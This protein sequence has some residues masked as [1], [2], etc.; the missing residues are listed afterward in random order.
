[1][2]SLREVREKS[3]L[4]FPQEK[5]EL[6]VGDICYHS[7]SQ[8]GW[9]TPRHT[10]AAERG[11]TVSRVRGEKPQFKGEFLLQGLL[12]G[13]CD[14]FDMYILKYVRHRIEKPPLGKSLRS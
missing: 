3:E 9:N 14:T 12:Q 11:L 4:T 10:Q 6:S 2:G 13:I 5:L 1:M 8:S 7:W